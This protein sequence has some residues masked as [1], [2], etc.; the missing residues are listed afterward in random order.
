MCNSQNFTSGSFDIF[1]NAFI[2]DVCGYYTPFLPHVLEYWK[3]KDEPNILFITYE[4]MKQ[5]LPSIIKK[6]AAFLQKPIS[7]QDVINLADHLSFK[8][9]KKNKAVNKEDFLEKD[10]QYVL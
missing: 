5:D 1:F 6:T 8:N 3:R 7:D 2:E 10:V 9:M 4:E